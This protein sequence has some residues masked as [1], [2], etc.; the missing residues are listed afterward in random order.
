MA[1][2]SI[3]PDSTAPEI[4]LSRDNRNLPALT[5]E[6][7]GAVSIALDALYTLKRTFAFWLD[8]AGALKLL[9]DKAD[10]IGG[11]FT[12]DL[13]RQREGLGGKDHLGR[14]IL[15]KSRV[16]RLLAIL[17]RLEEVQQW[18]AKLSEGQRFEWASPEAVYKHCPLF[19][20]QPDDEDAASSRGAARSTTARLIEALEA[21][22]EE[23]AKNRT[24]MAMH[25]DA[26]L[27]PACGLRPWSTYFPITTRRPYCADWQRA[28][29][30]APKPTNGWP[31]PK[32]PAARRDTTLIPR[33]AADADAIKSGG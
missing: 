3:A 6:E 17:A 27:P 7:Q 21:L 12:F 23:R 9:R 10:R 13:L 29:S 16:S 22:D 2:S 33:C 1:A 4:G 30:T 11:R 18:R 8:I 19:F 28:C 24:L 5:P 31:R 32:L 20:Q 26:A 25:G 14:E 15:S